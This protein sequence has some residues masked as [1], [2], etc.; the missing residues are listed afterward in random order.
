MIQPKCQTISCKLPVRPQL[1][2]KTIICSP[3]IGTAGSK[4]L[5]MSWEDIVLDSKLNVWKYRVQQH[6]WQGG[7][8]RVV[9]VDSHHD[10]GGKRVTAWWTNYSIADTTQCHTKAGCK[11]TQANN[12]CKRKTATRLKT[13]PDQGKTIREN[14]AKSA[15]PFGSLQCSSKKEIGKQSLLFRRF[16]AHEWP[17]FLGSASSALRSEFIPFQFIRK[18]KE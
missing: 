3:E 5:T 8:R 4:D 11:A 1:W 6:E 18:G 17:Q 9:N 13:E 7:A 12:T 15:K 14:T 2:S 10:W 16:S